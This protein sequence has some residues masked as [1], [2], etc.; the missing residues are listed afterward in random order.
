MKSIKKSG[1]GISSGALGILLIISLLISG[2]YAYVKNQYAMNKDLEAN[3]KLHYLYL[4]SIYYIRN[5]IY[6]ETFYDLSYAEDDVEIE[7]E[8]SNLLK[9][10]SLYLNYHDIELEKTFRFDLD[11]YCIY[12]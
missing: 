7:I 10:A 8:I 4:E 5:E 1:G 2:E 9:R 6:E 12:E 11:C 3:L